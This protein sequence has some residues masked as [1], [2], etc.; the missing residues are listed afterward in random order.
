MSRDDFSYPQFLASVVHSNSMQGKTLKDIEDDLQTNLK[1]GLN[2]DS[3][4]KASKK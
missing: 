4:K 2:E 3:V 1:S